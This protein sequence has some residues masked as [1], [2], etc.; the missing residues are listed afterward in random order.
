VQITAAPLTQAGY[1]YLKLAWPGLLQGPSTNR[2]LKADA[3]K[4]L[5][6]LH[7]VAAGGDAKQ[8]SGLDEALKKAI[9]EANA[10]NTALGGIV[11][12]S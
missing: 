3:E 1:D 11:I 4:I 7:R 10:A 5:Q 2:Q 6:A 9:A 12:L 8:A